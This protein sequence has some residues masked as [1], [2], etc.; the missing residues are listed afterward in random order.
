MNHESS[1]HHD[2]EQCT[3]YMDSTRPIDVSARSDRRWSQTFH[4]RA[5][6]RKP[7]ICQSY[8][9]KCNPTPAATCQNAEPLAISNSGTNKMATYSH[10]PSPTGQPSSSPTMSYISPI[11]L[12]YKK[13]LL[14]TAPYHPPL[15]PKY[16]D[17]EPNDLFSDHQRGKCRAPSPF[18]C[19]FQSVMQR[20]PPCKEESSI[21]PNISKVRLRLTKTIR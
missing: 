4:N 20:V 17:S 9:I 19:F 18:P 1:K 16:F 7:L 12:S 2:I 13:S 3:L 10:A 21:Q 14:L 6:P 5:L 15:S 11:P 8:P